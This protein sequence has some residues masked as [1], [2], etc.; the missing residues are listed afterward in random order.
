MSTLKKESCSLEDR[1][2]SLES[3]DD[4]S[5]DCEEIM[6]HLA[7]VIERTSDKLED[8]RNFVYPNLMKTKHLNYIHNMLIVN[9]DFISIVQFVSMET[10]NP[11]DKYDSNLFVRFN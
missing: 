6:K 5:G 11:V 1:S 2:I 3:G 4:L 8:V 10:Y 7:A 9:V